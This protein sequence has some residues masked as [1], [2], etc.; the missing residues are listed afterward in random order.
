[1]ITLDICHILL[2]KCSCMCVLLELIML[3]ARCGWFGYFAPIHKWTILLVH[4]NALITCC[5][6][7][8]KTKTAF[9]QHWWPFFIIQLQ[10]LNDDI[11]LIRIRNWFCTNTE[12]AVA[13]DGIQQIGFISI[14][15]LAERFKWLKLYDVVFVQSPIWTW[16]FT[17]WSSEYWACAARASQFNSATSPSSHVYVCIYFYQWA[18]GLLTQMLSI[19]HC[20]C[21]FFYT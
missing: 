12:H 15:Q 10:T 21:V 1:M 20:C 8:N 2:S 11:F 3:D 6:S 13:R 17:Q 7:C 16:F 18:K 9:K 19:F 14:V 5:C 4:M